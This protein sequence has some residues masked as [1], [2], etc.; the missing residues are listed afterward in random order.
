[1]LLMCNITIF[2]SINKNKISSLLYTKNNNISI[3]YI[4]YFTPVEN[5]TRYLCGALNLL[6]GA[7]DKILF[8]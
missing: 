5:I 8:T 7:Q 2:S 6:Y 4:L 3:K 1:M